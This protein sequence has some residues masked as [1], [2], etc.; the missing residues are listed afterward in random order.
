MRKCRRVDCLFAWYR[1]R[2]RTCAGL[3][4]TSSDGRRGEDEWEV[5]TDNVKCRRSKELGLI[6][7]SE[8]R[9][10]KRFN[11]TIWLMMWLMVSVYLFRRQIRGAR[12]RVCRKILRTITGFP[13]SNAECRKCVNARYFL[14]R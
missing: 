1:R 7:G 4:F 14:F 2:G 13:R 8:D 10:V 12:I 6:N 11:G 9:V 3:S 5:K